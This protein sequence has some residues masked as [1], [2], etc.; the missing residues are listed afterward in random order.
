MRVPLRWLSEWIDSPGQDALVERFTSA[1][2]EVESVLQSGP[3]FAGLLVGRVLECARHPNADRL[4]LCKVDAGAGEAL[5]II[6][7]A[8]NVAAGRSVALA[9]VGCTLPG[10][11]KIKRTKI[12][13]IASNGMICS[14][15]ELGIGD[16]H[17]GILLLEGDFA[18]G[19]PLAEALPG[20][21]GETVLDLEITP[22]RGDWLSMLGMAREVRAHFGGALRLPDFHVQEGERPVAGDIEVAIEDTAGCPAYLARVVRGVSVAPSPPWLQK[23]LE[24]AGLRSINNVVDVTNLV[25]LEFGQ[26][27]H[28]FDLDKLRGPVCVRAGRKGEAFRSLDGAQ[29]VL[30][31]ENLVIGDANGAIALAGVI[32][33]AA[34]EVDAGTVNLLLESAHFAPARVRRSARLCGLS[35]DASYRYERGVD[36]D[37]M[38]RSADRAARLLVEL[39]GGEVS[40]GRAEARGEALPRS[41]R[42]ALEPARLCRLLGVELSGEQATE[43]LERIEVSV[44]KGEAGALHCTP[45]A[46]RSDLW[47]PEDLIEE[48]AR[49][50]GYDNIEP[51]LPPARL[52]GTHEPRLRKAR[53]DVKQ[54]LVAS[55]LVEVMTV[56]W[57]PESDAAA[58]RLSE[59]DPRR[60]RVR[61]ANPINA[62]LPLLRGELVGSVLRTAARNLKLQNTRLRIFECGRVFRP[63]APG[64]LPAEPVQAVA[65][66][67]GVA[68]AG[69]AAPGEAADAASCFLQAKGAAE[70]LL[71]DFALDARFRAGAG[72]AYLHPEIS[73]A[74][75][76]EGAASAPIVLGEVHPET[77]AAFD[78][79]E[80]ALLVID[81]DALCALR[82]APAQYR[83]VSRYP[84]ARRDLSLWAGEDVPVGALLDAIRKTGGAALHSVEFFDRY[85]PG[86]REQGKVS[87]A[88]HLV[89]QRPDRT[90][91]DAEVDKAVRRV[92]G[93]LEQEFGAELRGGAAAKQGESS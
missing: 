86:G 49:I 17:E 46:Y 6:C 52:S 81:V 70:R 19:T 65:L 55:G 33:G 21:L 25:M 34:S 90:L 51:T 66:L 91:T 77:A 76:A 11:M 69:I 80:A 45:P 38:A 1:G 42:I 82:G 57:V 40:R 71:G 84:A 44:E 73:G 41:G 23:R 72:E 88:F 54:S 83:E 2:L 15:R 64:E 24:A 58:L 87:L 43:L 79:E 61:L 35:T 14:A 4:S 93:R 30:A 32:G 74:F 18:P 67:S 89:F 16:D 7:G 59:R 9:P 29:H 13:G 48:V 5:E 3:D 60:A 53:D 27:L 92:V 12:R 26:P 85:R 8:P 63:E 62:E 50:Y 10:G 78:V 39:A 22:N 20:E 31:G 28:A 36:P 68:A 47:L 37:G 75:E 56:P